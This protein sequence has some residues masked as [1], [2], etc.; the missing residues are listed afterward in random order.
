[1]TKTLIT[2]TLIAIAALAPQ[3]LPAAEADTTVRSA[4]QTA[5]WTLRDCI[6]YA[7]RENITLKESR[8]NEKSAE[9]DLKQAKAALYPSLSFSSGQ[10]ITNR[11][12][13][14]ESSTVSG[15]EILQT[16]STTSYTGSY[17]LNAQWTI[18]GG[19][20][21]SSNLKE[22]ELNQRIAA[23]G[24]GTQ[25]NTIQETI[26]QLYI[27]ILY[28]SEAVKVCE[29]TLSTSQAEQE[30]GQQL[31][32]AG[33]ISRADYA[34][35]CSQVSSDRYQL[36][37]AQATLEDYMLQLRQTLELDNT[38]TLELYLPEIPDDN[39]LDPLPDKMQ[40]YGA[41]LETRPEIASGNLSIELSDISLKSARS[42]SL[43]SISLSAGIGTNHISGSG[44]TF[45]EQ[46]KRGWNNSAG[47]TI[48][49]PIFSNLQN[50]SAIE[51][52]RI[53]QQVS[54]LNLTK[55]M[56]DL[57]KA[58][59]QLWLD[60]TSAQQQYIAAKDNYASASTS[61]DLVSEQFGLGMKNTVELLTEKNNLMSAMQQML[62]A[63]YMVVLGRE[64]LGFYSGQAIGTGTI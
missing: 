16:S 56:K 39:I 41:A 27:Q 59:E 31:L 50:K 49:I 36:V 22:Q 32:E 2:A 62:Q 47:L 38:A 17:G 45:T 51:K 11:P 34:Q 40:V 30:R 52:A 23:L 4:Q 12:F 37:S 3:R 8:L 58:I 21:L 53:Q 5:Q 6:E 42:G 1:M 63:K 24:T 57:Y 48:S 43:P 29:N 19:G 18:Y 15:S 44:Y 33:S 20:R 10:N 54:R 60:A 9:A 14:S 64:L 7:L 13:Q 35:L 46:I 55:Q 61:Y 26:T 25:A 28:A